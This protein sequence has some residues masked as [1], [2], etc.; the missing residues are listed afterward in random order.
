[1]KKFL[2]DQLDDIKQ[3]GY[4]NHNLK[5]LTSFVVFVKNNKLKTS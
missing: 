3:Y 1:M 5:Q 2:D 4:M